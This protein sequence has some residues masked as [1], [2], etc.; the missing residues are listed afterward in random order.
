MLEFPT[1]KVEPPPLQTELKIPPMTDVLVLQITLYAP[2]PIALPSAA[3]ILLVKPPNI[4]PVQVT[5]EKE[6]Q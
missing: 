2:A 3:L 4:E 6:I 1:I 5:F